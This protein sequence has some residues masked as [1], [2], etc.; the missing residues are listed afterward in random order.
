MN[1]GKASFL[2]LIINFGITREYMLFY[3]EKTKL[4]MMLYEKN[5]KRCP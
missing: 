2:T 3:Y 5:E 1:F 4:Q